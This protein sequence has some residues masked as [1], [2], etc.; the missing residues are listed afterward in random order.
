MFSETML[1][2]EERNCS[3]GFMHFV[4]EKMGYALYLDYD[5]SL[6]FMPQFEAN[7]EK[8]LKTCEYI[9]ELE[10]YCYEG[11]PRPPFLDE[12]FNVNL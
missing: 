3:D 10:D 9:G 6:E 5:T 2:L 1:K 11:G 4:L 12:D 8:I 7:A